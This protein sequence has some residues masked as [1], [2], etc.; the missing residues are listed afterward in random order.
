MKY[1]SMHYISMNYIV[2]ACDS[3][4]FFCTFL[5]PDRVSSSHFWLLIITFEILHCWPSGCEMVCKYYS[6]THAR[7]GYNNGSPGRPASEYKRAQQ[8]LHS[9]ARLYSLAGRPGD[10]FHE[11]DKH[12]N[13][14]VSVGYVRSEPRRKSVLRSYSAQSPKL[15]I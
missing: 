8:C 7:T 9:S 5:H 11:S 10:P 3:Y 12:V 2:L 14:S 1:N 6:S 13:C 15:R 4:E